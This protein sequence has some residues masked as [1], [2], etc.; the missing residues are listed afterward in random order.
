MF[1]KISVIAAFILFASLGYS[2]ININVVPEQT[3][4]L[5]SE[6]NNGLSTFKLKNGLTI[7]LSEDHTQNDVLGA[8]VVRGGAK[9]D[10]DNA[11]GTAHYFEHMMFKGS[12]SLGTTDYKSEKVYLDSIR[13]QYELLRLDR[14]NVEFRAAILK[15]IDKLSVKAAQYAIPNEFD[16]V[17]SAIGGTG[18]N[19]YTNYENIVY[20][21]RFPKQSIEQWVELSVDR[22]NAPVFRLFQ[23]ELET[24]YEEKNRS[25]DNLFRNI[26]QEVYTNFYPNSVYGKKTVLGTVDDLKNPSIMAVET[27]F[28][29]YYNAGNMALVLIGDFD[30]NSI[31][32]LLKAKFGTWRDGEKAVMPSATEKEFDGRVV[33]KRKMAPIALGILGFR[34]VAI[35]HKDEL[36]LDVIAKLLTNDNTTG[37]IDT[38]T[39]S[40]KLLGAQVFMDKHYDKGGFFIFYLPKPIIQS[41][42]NGEKLVIQQLDKLK[43]GDFDEMLLSAVKVSMKKKKILELEN[44]DNKLHNIIDSY[45]TERD[46]DEK[47]YLSDIDNIGKDDIVRIA[48]KYF[49]ENYLSFQS[50]MGFPK[51][52]TLDKPNNT[53]L[54]FNEEVESSIMAK[55]ILSMNTQ[56]IEPNYVDFKREVISREI[57]E[58]MHFYYVNNTSNNI[59][60]L[61]IRIAL[62]NIEEPK[63]DKLAFYLNN[64]GTASLTHAEYKKNMQLYGSEVDF[65][66]TKDYFTISISGFDNKFDQ[67]ILDVSSLINDFS[68]NKGLVKQML[69]SEKMEVKM[70]KK[71]LGSKISM[72]N[73]YALYGENSSYLKRLTKKDI[74]KIDYSEYKSLM[75]LLL[76][77]E[78]HIHYVGSSEIGKVSNMIANT[79]SFAPVL[80]RGNSPYLRDL[81]SYSSDRLF[82]MED[83]KAIQSHIRITIPANK[84]DE[85]GRVMAKPFNYYFGL[86]MNS[87]MFKEIREYRSLAYTAY[88]Y[89]AVPYRFDKQ[90]YFMAVMSTQADKTNES[91]ELLD[92]LLDNFPKNRNQIPALQSYLMRSF[93][94]EMP[95]FRYKSFIVQYWKKQ[96]Y[97]T[98]PRKTAYDRYRKLA[99]E[100]IEKFYE[101]NVLNKS[102]TTSVVGNVKR[103]DVEKLSKN[104]EIRKFKLKEVLN[105]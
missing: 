66:T 65:Y 13:D 94:S 101:T 82:V 104:K 43:R 67:T 98:D 42:S 51:K 3:K 21:N 81:S 50:K 47:S 92:S 16:K 90:G 54:T 53:P 78:V 84:L 95:S 103:F 99:M 31:R 8:I 34:S 45:M 15:N 59:F 36:A 23:S 32:E 26:I 7:Y 69:R 24:V 17:I 85:Y 4:S 56:E 27:Y 62:G 12:T 48:N 75:N 88:A 58:N 29:S 14:D 70:M 37:L 86:G 72:L 40:S 77:K 18:V 30:A 80:Q 79:I 46:L 105:Y 9:L 55:K 100:D 87:V 2:Q 20:H 49:G 71:D 38:L 5:E 33:V 19:A 91:I 74:K 61:K 96:G 11:S 63:I 89:Y 57:K 76:S 6:T 41:L 25:M 28:K 102:A 44:S 52:H 60:T 93:N 10:P 1:K 22:F 39:T 68:E 97:N 64:T 35:A 83:K 73:E